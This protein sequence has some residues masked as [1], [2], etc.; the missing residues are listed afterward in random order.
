MALFTSTG[1]AILRPDEVGPLI[2]QPVQAAAVATQVAQTV[3]TRSHE[4]RVPIV[5]ADP[6][7]GWV[8]E[9]GEIALSDADLDEV[10]ITPAKVA[11]LTVITRELAEDSDPAAARVVGDGLSRDIARR[12]DEAFFG[13]LAAP[14]PAG[15]ESMAGVTEQTYATPVADLDAFAA[16][17]AAG[18]QE[19]VSVSSFVTDPATALTL[20]QLKEGNASARPL[21]GQDPTRPSSRVILGVPLYVSTAVTAGTVWAIPRT[22]V[23]V[24]MRNNATLETSRE[25]Y[26]SSD[27]IAIRA[28]MR[29]GFAFPHPAAIVKITEAVG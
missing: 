5:A 2:V 27:Q 25:A 6:T 16:A 13:A 20:S 3:T 12:L 29:V 10:T 21:L 18:E 28:T 17:I 24:V 23:M 4:F 7:A 1:S 15:L 22:R 9:G 8:A 11:G 26:F 19:G 14:A